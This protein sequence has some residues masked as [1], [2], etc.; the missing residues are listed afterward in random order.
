MKRNTHDAAPKTGATENAA[1]DKPKGDQ[2]ENRAAKTGATEG[3]S[4]GGPGAAAAAD[5]AHAPRRAGEAWIFSALEK[6]GG[7]PLLE[8]QG[9]F[10][11]P[12]ATGERKKDRGRAAIATYYYGMGR[13]ADALARGRLLAAARDAYLAAADPYKRFRFPRLRYR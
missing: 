11:A 7:V 8:W 6:E 5:G 3:D 13:R 10:P 9:N 2:E 4:A 1:A 12:M